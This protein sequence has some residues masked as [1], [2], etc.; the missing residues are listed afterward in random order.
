MRPCGAKA[1]L[2]RGLFRLRNSAAG[3]D[4]ESARAASAAT[5]AVPAFARSRT[6][7]PCRSAT[8]PKAPSARPS[9]GSWAVRHGNIA[10]AGIRLPLHM[11]RG[12]RPRRS[13]RTCRRLILEGR[14]CPRARF[15]GSQVSG[16]SRKPRY[17]RRGS[18][19]STDRPRNCTSGRASS[20]PHR[21]RPHALHRHGRRHQHAPRRCDR[22]RRHASR[23]HHHP[24]ASQRRDHHR[25][26]R[27]RDHHRHHRRDH[28]RR[29]HGQR[30]Q[31]SG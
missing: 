29:H 17:S 18:S 4:R 22:R 6:G 10:V 28:L 31:V 20:D 2:G 19:S 8:N 9:S 3:R 21:R 13:A 5:P 16:L 7:L 23:R 24:H 30:M 27:R 14:Y 26:H 1:P 25:R 12:S 15:A 11:A